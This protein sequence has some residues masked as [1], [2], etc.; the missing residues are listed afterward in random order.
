MANTIIN[1]PYTAALISGAGAVSIPTA[2]FLVG[3]INYAAVAQTVTIALTDGG[4]NA[5]DVPQ[6]P[7]LAAGQVL[8]YPPPG[9]PVVGLVATPSGAPT[10]TIAML[11]RISAG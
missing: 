1:S 9:L 4:G 11:Y 6:I 10:G 8:T 2:R 5:A 7:A 3:F